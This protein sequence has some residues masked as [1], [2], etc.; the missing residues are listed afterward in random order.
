MRKLSSYQNV[1][2]CGPNQGITITQP[3]CQI[4]PDESVTGN[5]CFRTSP[6]NRSYWTYKVFIDPGT[7][8]NPITYIGIPICQAIK[9]TILTLQ[10]KIDG[11]G[12]FE[13]IDF[14]LHSDDP[15]LGSPPNGFQWLIININNRYQKGTSALYRIAISGNFP[16]AIEP[17]SLVSNNAKI[18]FDC[19]GC[20]QVPTCPTPANLLVTKD[21]IQSISSNNAL[22]KYKISVSNTGQ[23]PAAGVTLKD[24]L[25][26]SFPIVTIGNITFSDPR[27]KIIQQ[28]PG[29]IY[30]EGDLGDFAPGDHQTFDITVPVIKF[31]E[32]GL[33]LFT[34][35]VTVSDSQ[36]TTTSSDTTE[37]SIPVVQLRAYKCSDINLNQIHYNISI[38]SV[39]NSPDTNLVVNDTLTIPDGLIIQ[40]HSFDT[41]SATFVNSQKSVP[42]NQDIEGPVTINFTCTNI[43][44]STHSAINFTIDMSIVSYKTFNSIQTISNV[45]QNVLISNPET[46]IYLGTDNIPS[47]VNIDVITTLKSNQVCTPNN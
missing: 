35:T 2:E 37:N 18:T 30:I 43:P 44:L 46:Q 22:I 47:T 14:S 26:F 32:P 34:N 41:C 24:Q 23:L 3:S 19:A 25:R 7:N 21:S 4:L 17:I 6:E 27:L 12:S 11:C 15:I 40:F 42:I 8:T 29:I 9:E 13:R 33:F 16:V 36:G 38:V 1:C 20:F 10:E 45:L 39:D 31:S 28:G 5:P